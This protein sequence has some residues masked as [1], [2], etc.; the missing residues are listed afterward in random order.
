[1]PNKPNKRKEKKKIPYPEEVPVLDKDFDNLGLTFD[2]IDASKD[3]ID[4]NILV[5]E[6]KINAL[7]EKHTL[8]GTPVLKWFIESADDIDELYYIGAALL[9]L[10]KMLP[11][12]RKLQS[13]KGLLDIV[14]KDPSWVAATLGKANPIEDTDIANWI[15]SID[16]DK[17]IIDPDKDIENLPK[18]TPKRN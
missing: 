5:I 2:N 14:E 7:T 13:K 12:L 11:E 6:K 10:H 8:R 1:M 3:D 16:P 15:E 17:D 18:A 4:R 9:K